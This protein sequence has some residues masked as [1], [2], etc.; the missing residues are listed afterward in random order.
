MKRIKTIMGFSETQD[1]GPIND[2][3]LIVQEFNS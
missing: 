2:E 1:Y 3:D